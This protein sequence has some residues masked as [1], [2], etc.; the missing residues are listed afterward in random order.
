MGQVLR[1]A[2][3]VAAGERGDDALVQPTALSVF[4]VL[5]AGLWVLE[6]RRAQQTFESPRIT[7]GQ[8]AIYEHAHALL[9]RQANAGRE[10]R[11]LFE[12]AGH[13]VQFERLQLGKGVLHQ[14]RDLL[15]VSGSSLDRA[16]SR[17]RAS[18]IR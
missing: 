15:R 11:L 16:R 9:E 8:L 2:H 10:R 13:A 4:N 6:L 3:P 1:I 17:A 14:H 12:R 18:A 5:D 7:P